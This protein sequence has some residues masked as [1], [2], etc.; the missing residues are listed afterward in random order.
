MSTN[1]LHPVGSI[2]RALLGVLAGRSDEIVRDGRRLDPAV[3]AM[4]KLA[5]RFS[6]LDTHDVESSRSDMHRTAIFGPRGP[7]SVHSW[8]R[9]LPGPAGPIR[10]RFYRDANLDPTPPA[11]CFFHGGGWVIGDLDSHDGPCR[12]LAARSGA[13]VMSVD[14]RLA[15]EAPYPAAVEDSV[16]AY[17]WLSTHAGE[18]GVDADAIALMGDSAGGNLAAL[19]ALAA[20]DQGLR[21]PALQALVYPATDF[22]MSLSSVDT[23]ADGFL[24][25]RDAMEW[26]RGQYIDDAEQ[27]RDPAASPLYADLE[28]VA[29]AL[30]FTAGFDPLR[31]EGGAFAA[32]LAGYGVPVSLRCF[33][34]L[35]HGF[36]NLAVTQ[37]CVAAYEEVDDAVG[38]ALR[39]GLPGSADGPA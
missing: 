15:P 24:L 1:R 3:Q 17:A 12:V 25:T 20:R 27:W 28:G 30:V 33:D 32:R 14:Y 23:F 38:H 6:P 29:P 13:V 31:D 22:T 26:F 9:D 34:D 21:P 8:E 39:H 18:L 11:I 35:I 36:Y 5:G 19:V 4:L 37:A 7:K 16:A 10:V 2:A